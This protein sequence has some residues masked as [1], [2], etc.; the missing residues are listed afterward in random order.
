MG[1]LIFYLFI[2]FGW[3]G[4]GVHL[5]KSSDSLI[6]INFKPNTN[7]YKCLYHWNIITPFYE[8]NAHTQNK[9]KIKGILTLKKRKFT[10]II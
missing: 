4:G 5:F 8:S 9:I 6:G 3:G 7:H 1:V 2:Y 10:L